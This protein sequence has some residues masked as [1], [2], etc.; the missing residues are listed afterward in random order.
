MEGEGQTEEAQMAAAI[1]ASLDMSGA[2]GKR[3]AG[4]ISGGLEEGEDEDLR[5]A[6]ALSVGLASADQ[7]SPAAPAGLSESAAVAAARLLATL[8][9]EPP[10]DEAGTARLQLRIPSGIS[11]PAGAAGVGAGA[12]ALGLHTT[13]GVPSPVVRRFRG[14]ESMRTVRV[15]AGAMWLGAFAATR[16]Q[17]PALGGAAS[18][19]GGL[20]F[21]LVAF[22]LVA[23]GAPPRVFGSEQYVDLTVSDA[24]LCPSAALTLRP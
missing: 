13:C 15:W 14:N 22:A 3:S 11:S 12:A 2:G 24:G 17:A 4:A 19:E 6:L 21:P 5:R 10:A 20:P 18:G 1:A 7:R 8:P 23:G 9:E 16:A